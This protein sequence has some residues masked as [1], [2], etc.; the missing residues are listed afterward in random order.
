MRAINFE[1][2]NAQKIYSDY[3]KR[4]KRVTAAL[5]ADDQLDVLMEVN[6]HI[7]ESVE[8][9]KSEG[10]LEALLDSMDSFGAPEE[11]L[12]PLVAEKKLSQA[13]RTLNPIH[14]FR[15]L[16]LNIGNGFAYLVFSLLY[17]LLF[18]FFFLIGAK[19]FNP[20]K[21]G[22]FYEGDQFRVLGMTSA[23]QDPSVHEVLGMWFIPVMLISCAVLY[24]CIT[25][26]LRLK[27][28]RRS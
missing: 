19:L 15:A 18:G 25:L 8:R 2:K 3:I 21:V 5:D 16:V 10:E 7:Y 22:L 17:L 24:I 14:V 13:T 4:V 20:D 6:S 26:L 11:V 1:D 27:R 23:Y 12:K 28:M 9:K